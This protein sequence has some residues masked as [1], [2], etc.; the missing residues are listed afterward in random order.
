MCWATFWANVS[1]NRLVTLL[2]IYIRWPV[3]KWLN[4]WM[5]IC[6]YIFFQNAYVPTYIQV[7]KCQRLEGYVKIRKSMFN[8]LQISLHRLTKMVWSGFVVVLLN[9]PPDS[10]WT[11][12]SQVVYLW[13]GPRKK[14]PDV[15]W[16]WGTV[17]F[18]S[19]SSIFV[20]MK[21]FLFECWHFVHCRHVCSN[22]GILF[23]C[24]HFCLKA[25]IF[26]I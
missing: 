2:K 6:R 8:F 15:E 11:V 18:C 21:A 7:K 4:V 14:H 16:T 26:V 25:G 24:G 12:S 23:E 17:K 19:N 5:Y 1:Q 13:P 9:W 22:A 10:L 3:F 20:R